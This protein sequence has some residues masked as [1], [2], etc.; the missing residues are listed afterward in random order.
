MH[1]LQAPTLISFSN[2]YLPFISNL[3]NLQSLCCNLVV[4]ESHRPVKKV[5]RKDIR[6]SFWPQSGPYPAKPFGSRSPSC[7]KMWSACLSLEIDFQCLNTCE[8][9]FMVIFL[10]QQISL[11]NACLN[12]NLLWP[13]CTWLRMNCFTP[14]HLKCLPPFHIAHKM[15]QF[16]YIIPN[17][18]GESRMFCISYSIHILDFMCVFITQIINEMCVSTVPTLTITYPI[19]SYHNH[20]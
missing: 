16:L 15:G 19:G 5:H 17:T 3:L 13:Y 1:Y 6:G 7:W 8:V 10:I 4:L 12:F 11:R 14:R 9:V 20:N 18:A 2:F